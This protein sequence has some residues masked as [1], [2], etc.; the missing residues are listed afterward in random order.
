VDIAILI[1]LAAVLLVLPGR[2]DRW[3]LLRGARP[4]TLAALA[5]V[6]LA[7]L[8]ALPAAIAVCVSS[9]DADGDH[10]VARLAA[11]PGLLLVALAAGRAVAHTVAVRRR[12]RLLQAAAQALH[13]PETEHGVKVLPVPELLAFA[14]GTDAFVSEGLLE[15]LPGPER[16]AVLAHEHEHTAGRHGRLLTAA[17]AVRRAWFGAHAARAAEAALHR[18]LDVLAD[19]AAA[20]DVGDSRVLRDALLRLA[21]DHDDE[22][23]QVRLGR[24]DQPTAATGLVEGAVQVITV[25]L[26]LLV[27]AGVCVAL[28]VGDEVVGVL[29]CALAVAVFAY[30]T[31]PALVRRS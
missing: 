6:T 13:L 23:V 28:H 1:A 15:R 7:G 3:A 21:A 18:E 30:L 25:A 17:G 9:S 14:A 26:A 20:R 10:V 24:L 31:A 27:L 2:V 16:R 22:A 29:A 19:D 5:A 11:V 12:W 4:R 8:S